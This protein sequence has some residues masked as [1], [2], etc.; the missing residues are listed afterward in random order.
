MRIGSLL[1][2]LHIQRVFRVFRDS[3]TVM[4]ELLHMGFL[5]RGC[6]VRFLIH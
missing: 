3:T 1:V 5:V 2:R 4:L 6:G